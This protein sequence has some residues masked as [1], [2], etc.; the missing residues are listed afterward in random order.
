M[1]E[2]FTNGFD[3]KL[4]ICFFVNDNI[5]FSG[6][7]KVF[8]ITLPPRVGKS[9]NIDMLRL[10]LEVQSDPQADISRSIFGGTNIS[11]KREIVRDHFQ[12]Y[13]VIHL[14]LAGTYSSYLD[15]FCCFWEKIFNEFRCHSYLRYSKKL[16][17]DDK[18]LYSQCCQHCPV[19][20]RDV[21]PSLQALLENSLLYLSEF[22]VKHHNEKCII[23]ID[24][25]DAPPTNAMFSVGTSNELLE[26]IKLRDVILGN[27]LKNTKAVNYRFAIL[28]GVADIICTVAPPLRSLS[29]FQFLQHEAFSEFYGINE[30]E[31]Q[32]LTENMDD[33]RRNLMKEFYNGYQ[34]NGLNIY[35]TWSI[36]K[37]L[38]MNEIQP[39]WIE[40]TTIISY[41]FV[42]S[43][44]LQKC[45]Q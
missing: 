1:S 11:R 27:V 42:K 14:N 18:S 41:N 17:N 7:E 30:Y 16:T 23:L 26:I 40:E 45:H 33:N 2:S 3:G 28:T 35:N 37:S 12:K 8:L 13:P 15:A 34:F 44:N 9:V 25:F 19:L 43:N 38:T 5:G 32:K 24:E 10:F 29:R 31:F 22:L 21:K 20:N 36:V 6:P 4:L 39:F